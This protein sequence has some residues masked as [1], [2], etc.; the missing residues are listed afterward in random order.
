LLSVF[1]GKPE[2]FLAAKFA[3]DN[4]DLLLDAR[5]DIAALVK[6]FL[7]TARRLSPDEPFNKTLRDMIKSGEAKGAQ[8]LLSFNGRVALVVRMHPKEAE[9]KEPADISKTI[10]FDLFTTI[11]SGGS[12]LDTLLEGNENWVR[13]RKQ[14]HI[15]YT[16]KHTDPATSSAPSESVVILDGERI[17]AGTSVAFVEECLTRK[18][19]SLVTNAAYTQALAES[20]SEGHLLVYATPRF[21]SALRDMTQWLVRLN[22][23]TPFGSMRH[24]LIANQILAMIPA[25]TRPMTT[26]LVA[27]AD[28]I[29]VRGFSFE[30]LRSSLP[31]VA[32]LTPDFLGRIATMLARSWAVEDATQQARDSAKMQFI[33]PLQLVG[34][35]ARTYFETHAEED[36]VTLTALKA[37]LPAVTL[38]D[39]T[40]VSTE[41]IELKRLSDVVTLQHKEFGEITHV[42]PLTDAQKATI[43]ATLAK[44]DEAA[45]EYLVVEG[46]TTGTATLSTLVE[47]GWLKSPVSLV[48]ENFDELSPTLEASTL[49]VR[50]PGSQEISFERAPD[51]LVKARR[52]VALRRLAVERNLAILDAA[53]Q[54]YFAANPDASAEVSPEDLAAKEIKPEIVPISGEDYS[55]VTLVRD[56]SNLSIRSARIGTVKYRRP[57][58][59][60]V[61]DKHLARLKA[62][63][64]AVSVYFAKNPAAELVISGEV[65]SDPVPAVPAVPAAPAPG[66]TAPATEVSDAPEPARAPQTEADLSGLVIRRDYQFIKVSL[67]NGHEIE[68]PR[69]TKKHK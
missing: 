56:H 17:S 12:A 43:I 15:Y 57:L 4:A 68:V 27:R 35:T 5:L 65:Y 6:A 36:S 8:P 50:T 59:D 1:P 2:P 63:E 64:K 18:E 3:P 26:V 29:L 28:G 7:E 62:L 60:D 52:A 40:T 9:E 31:G 61:R 47:G 16:V 53:G 32:L 51:A 14:G 46:D 58:A 42:M 21:F 25:P 48:G 30:S 34:E 22:P 23:S 33:A 55:G 20:A 44:I 24:T 54:R 38:P 41:E 66:A 37:A 49:I 67:G 39:F 13:E 19:G 45:V 10:P 11:E 69:S